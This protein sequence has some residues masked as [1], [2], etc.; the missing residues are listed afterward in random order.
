MR[1][2]VGQHE[3]QLIVILDEIQQTGA[4]GHGAASDARDQ[5]ILTQQ[6]GQFV[7]HQ[8]RFDFQ[9]SPAVSIA[10]LDLEQHIGCQG[11]GRPIK[12]PM[13]DAPLFPWRCP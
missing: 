2:L 1:Q 11:I 13:P 4:D 6:S 9:R 12:R 7:A 5:V 3:C 8:L 10:D